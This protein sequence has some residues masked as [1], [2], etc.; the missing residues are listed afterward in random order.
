MILFTIAMEPFLQMIN[1]KLTGVKITKNLHIKTL[2]Y[3]DDT[4]VFIGNQTDQQVLDQVIDAYEK[5][6]GALLNADKTQSLKL[7]SKDNKAQIE[8]TGIL[9]TNNHT[10]RVNANWKKVIDKIRKKMHH[11][12]T[13]NLSLIGK[14]TIINAYII[15]VIT[16][17]S[18]IIPPSKEHIKQLNKIIK[19][20]IHSD[21][22]FGY[23]YEDII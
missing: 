7:N 6:S 3:A 23:N 17:T 11:F 4:V 19:N 9:Y 22:P 16:Y 8:I 15:S 2:A 10:T 18:R 5:G 20:F 14:C 13:R 1:T 21:I 12:N